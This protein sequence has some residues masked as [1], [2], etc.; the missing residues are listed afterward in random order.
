MLPNKKKVVSERTRPTSYFLLLTSLP[1]PIVSYIVFVQPKL[2]R[3]AIHRELERLKEIDLLWKLD[4]SL[5]FLALGDLAG[6]KVLRHRRRLTLERLAFLHD[7]RVGLEV[8]LFLCGALN[9]KHRGHASLG[10]KGG[11]GGRV[12]KDR[13]DRPVVE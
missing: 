3:L 9:E 12:A 2:R 6:H 7:R 11:L 5:D 8:D 10:A 1:I 4:Q 13:L